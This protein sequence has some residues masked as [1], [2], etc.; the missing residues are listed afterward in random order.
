MTQQE[1]L[2]ALVQK[3]NQGDFH[4]A[5]YKVKS[6]HGYRTDLQGTVEE[7]YIEQY[8]NSEGVFFREIA[9]QVVV[10]NID[11]AR[12]LFGE[13]QKHARDQFFDIID[14][15]GLKYYLQQAVI[16]NN[17]IDYMYEAVFGK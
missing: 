15:N 4:L 8:T 7:P 3:A 13:E 11:F 1:K 14:K 17:P 2:E 9:W 12:A 6:R 10:F 5:N 16:S